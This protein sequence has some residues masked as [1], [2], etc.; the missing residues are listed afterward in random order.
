MSPL[1]TSVASP[2]ICSTIFSTCLSKLNKDSLPP[3]LTKTPR[4]DPRSPIPAL[5][6]FKV[7]LL[8]H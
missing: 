5:A 4:R 3:S 8:L 2:I 7:T 1:P 6:R